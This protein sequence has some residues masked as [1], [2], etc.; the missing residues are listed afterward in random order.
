MCIVQK[1]ET[2][3]PWAPLTALE[4]DWGQWG[5]IMLGWHVA[6]GVRGHHRHWELVE[7]GWVKPPRWT[8]G[9]I[10]ACVTN[11]H[12]QD[13]KP[14]SVWPRQLGYV[15]SLFCHDVCNV[16]PAYWPLRPR[17]CAAPVKGETSMVSMASWEPCR[18]GSPVADGTVVNALNSRDVEVGQAGVHCN[19]G[20]SFPVEIHG[21][22]GRKRIPSPPY[23]LYFPC[24]THGTPVQHP[25][26]RLYRTHCT[27]YRAHCAHRTVPSKPRLHLARW[28][29]KR[30]SLHCSWDK[31]KKKITILNDT[32]HFTTPPK[33]KT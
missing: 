15:R 31:G 22:N 33:K 5:W 26:Y 9:T 17:G 21:G 25:P 28:T 2:H 11:L 18:N 16:A 27:S 1:D 4:V 6:R 24:P 32:L 10:A 20:A 12:G 29:P 3:R 7:Q 8:M 19:T 14:A 30:P 23:P 13:N